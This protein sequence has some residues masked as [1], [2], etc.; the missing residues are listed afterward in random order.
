MGN[1]WLSVQNLYN[2]NRSAY[3]PPTQR[4]YFLSMKENHYCIDFVELNDLWTS[5]G[6]GLISV[7]QF[8]I[9]IFIQF[10]CHL[11]DNMTEPSRELKDFRRTTAKGETYCWTLFHKQWN[12]EQFSKNISHFVIVCKKITD[13]QKER[14]KNMDKWEILIKSLGLKVH[15]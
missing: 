8:L 11:A 14:D 10:T 9:L 2:C 7:F 3:N 12:Y 1:C 5:L 4:N 15:C 13:I 6:I